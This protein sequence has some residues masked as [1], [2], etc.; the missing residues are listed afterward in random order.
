MLTLVRVAIGDLQGPC[1]QQLESSHLEHI[2]QQASS[3][4]RHIQGT[5]LAGHQQRTSS[6]SA[7]PTRDAGWECGSP[8]EASLGTGMRRACEAEWLDKEGKKTGQVL[9]PGQFRVLLDSEVT[10]LFEQAQGTR[11][12]MCGSSARLV[13]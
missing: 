11:P 12:L 6:R 8:E 4:L 9:A 10:R 7:Q 2:A 13:K 5:P 3:A 1:I